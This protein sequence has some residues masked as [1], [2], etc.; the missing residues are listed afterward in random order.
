MEV[1]FAVDK[2]EIVKYPEAPYV[3]EKEIEIF[4]LYTKGEGCEKDFDD[5]CEN[6]KCHYVRINIKNGEKI[7]FTCGRR[8]D[9]VKW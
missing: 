2:A 8:K 6:P 4:P 1:L 3:E 5:I 7:W 9:E